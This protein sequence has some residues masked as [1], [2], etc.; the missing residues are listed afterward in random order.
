MF[1]LV[2]PA[3]HPETTVILPSPQFGDTDR[4][5]SS[6]I[7]RRAIDGSIYTF[8]QKKQK[9]KSYLWDF[10]VTLHKALEIIEFYKAYNAVEIEAHW[11]GQTMTGYFKNNPFEGDVM[12]AALNSPGGGEYLKITIELEEK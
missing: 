12:S 9:A 3:N 7:V 6:L 1:R 4:L 11:G 5:R 8:V 10:N 2:A